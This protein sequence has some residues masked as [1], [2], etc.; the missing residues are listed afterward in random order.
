[1][2]VLLSPLIILLFCDLFSLF[3]LFMSYLFL[4]LLF[5]SEYFLLPVTYFLCSLLFPFFSCSAFVLLS[6]A[7]FSCYFFVTFSPFLFTCYFFSSVLYI[8]FGS[9]SA[10]FLFFFLS[11]LLPLDF[12]LLLCYTNF[13]YPFPIRFSLAVTCISL[14]TRP[15][16]PQL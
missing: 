14:L 6:Y 15:R 16:S 5:T 9:I 13:L 10:T 12:H 4:G 3:Y 2:F 11:F 7:F 1:M 8:L